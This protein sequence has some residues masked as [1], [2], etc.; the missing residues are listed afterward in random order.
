M[1]MNLDVFSQQSKA[2]AKT[3]TMMFQWQ[4]MQS[5]GLIDSQIKDFA[6]PNHW[7]EFFP[8]LAQKDLM[9]MGLKVGLQEKGAC[10]S[11]LVLRNKN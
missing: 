8:P 3:G 2:A 4:I 1:K 10:F 9:G 6:D 5:L 11:K 7:L